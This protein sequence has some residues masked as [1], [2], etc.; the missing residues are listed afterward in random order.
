I[1]INF[2]DTYQRA[3]LYSV[4]LPAIAG[5]EGAGT[6]TALG[7][8][9]ADLAV[10]GRVAWTGIAGSYAEYVVVP[11]ERTVPLTSG[12]D[13]RRATA[14]LLQGMTA[15]YLTHDTHPL[16][17]GETC[18]IHAAAGGVGLLFCQMARR[19]GARVMGTVSTPEKAALAS[20]VGADPVVL[21]TR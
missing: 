17:P 15:H 19:R 13:F 6:I 18:V 8:G 7:S 11:A 16:A 12:I 5:Q 4:P 21:S 2:I 14:A 9:V 1:G 3:G 20:R 10:G